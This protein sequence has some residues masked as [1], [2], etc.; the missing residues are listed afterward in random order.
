[1]SFCTIKF[2][3]IAPVAETC[4]K[5]WREWYRWRAQ[6]QMAFKIRNNPN[7]TSTK[8]PPQ[9]AAEP[10]GS[11]WDGRQTNAASVWP[12]NAPSALTTPRARYRWRCRYRRTYGG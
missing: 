3:G 9:P 12:A 2:L 10:A 4:A 7:L 11:A 5:F 8:N 6:R 1:M